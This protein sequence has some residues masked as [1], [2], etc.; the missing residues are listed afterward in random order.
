MKVFAVLLCFMVSAQ[1]VGCCRG[2]GGAPCARCSH[3]LFVPPGHAL[4][5]DM[6]MPHC[7]PMQIFFILFIA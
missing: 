3:N 6:P 2:A 5:I 4:L 1:H 7:C